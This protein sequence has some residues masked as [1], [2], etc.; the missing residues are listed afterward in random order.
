MDIDILA[1]EKRTCDLEALRDEVGVKMIGEAAVA[2]LF[3]QIIVN[4]SIVAP[5]QST[6]QV[7]AVMRFP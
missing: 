3:C 6:Q 1:K 5:G 7:P 2:L 4:R